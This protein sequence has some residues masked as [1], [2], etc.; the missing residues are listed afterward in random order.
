MTGKWTLSVSPGMVKAFMDPRHR[1]VPNMPTNLLWLIIFQASCPP[2]FRDQDQEKLNLVWPVQASLP[3]TKQTLSKWIVE[4]ISLAYEVSG[5]PSPIKVRVHSARGM[6]AS[7]ALWLRASIQ[8]FCD[9]AGWSSPLTFIRFYDLDVG[10]TP[11]DQVLMS[12]KCTPTTHRQVFG[13]MVCWY[14]ILVV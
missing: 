13:C 3:A 1:N 9:V 5:R 12:L 11:G 14:S 6:A 2:R 7:K 8:D 4:A 10:A